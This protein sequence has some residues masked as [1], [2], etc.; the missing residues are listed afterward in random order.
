MCLSH[1]LYCFETLTKQYILHPIQMWVNILATL[2][3]TEHV[4][5]SLL[6]KCKLNVVLNYFD[7]E[8]MLLC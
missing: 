7:F 8:A 1:S 6:N 3:N 2:M 5:F 4:S